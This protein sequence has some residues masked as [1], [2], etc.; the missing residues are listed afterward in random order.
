MATTFF[1]IV[2]MGWL[3]S[4][5]GQLPLGSICLTSTQIFVQEGPKKAWQFSMGVALVEIIYIR[6]ALSGIDWVYQHQTFFK[7]IGWVTVVFFIVFGVFTIAGAYKQQANKKGLLINNK[8]NRFLLGFSLSA[9]NPSQIPFWLVW[10]TY[11]IDSGT[12]HT[13]SFE[14]NL[15][16]MGA[17]LGTLCGLCVYMYGGNYLLTKL[18]LSNKKLNLFIGIIFLIAGAIQLYRMLKK[19]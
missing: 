5:L 15:F 7:I 14:Y 12:L 4:F 10:S 1:F 6:T 19:V 17:G 3:I 16:T 18:K 9:L 13:N 11:V 2:L 8:L